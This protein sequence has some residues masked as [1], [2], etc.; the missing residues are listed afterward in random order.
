MGET[1]KIP[2]ALDEVIFDGD[3]TKNISLKPGDIIH[4]PRSFF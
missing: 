4:V 3:L 1:S 2:V